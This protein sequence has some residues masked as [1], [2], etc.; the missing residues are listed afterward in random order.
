MSDIKVNSV[1]PSEFGPDMVAY[2]LT[3]ATLTGEQHDKGWTPT[4]GIPVLTGYS[5]DEILN[6]YAKAKQVVNQPSR[7]ETFLA[8]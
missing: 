7:V 6:A 3:V 5:E 4:Y 2:L 8:G 1:N